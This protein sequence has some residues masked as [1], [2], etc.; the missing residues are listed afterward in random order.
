MQISIRV[1]KR[2]WS[3]SPDKHCV[4][5]SSRKGLRFHLNVYT[6]P[7]LSWVRENNELYIMYSKAGSW[8][9]DGHVPKLLAPVAIGDRVPGW[10]DLSLTR[11]SKDM[12]SWSL[13]DTVSDANCCG[14][15]S[16]RDSCSLTVQKEGE[17]WAGN[18]PRQTV[19]HRLSWV[20]WVRLLLEVD[21]LLTELRQI[22]AH[23]SQIPKTIY[24]CMYFFFC[25]T[26]NYLHN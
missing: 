21:P 16:S 9:G 19:R 20:L 10:W 4:V 7:S 2:K 5:D 6:D 18:K 23:S 24:I 12:S 14:R 22:L 25:L 26:K 11:D 17:H 3:V 8:A 15:L 13:G 1:L